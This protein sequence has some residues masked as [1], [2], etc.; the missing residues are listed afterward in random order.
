[1]KLEKQ[2]NQLDQALV[3]ETYKRA[4]RANQLKGLNPRFEAALEKT[5]PPDMQRKNGVHNYFQ[6]RAQFNDVI[7]ISQPGYS[8]DHRQALV[9][10]L[11]DFN[12]EHGPAACSCLLQLEGESWTIQGMS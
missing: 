5:V 7:R 6:W 10:F 11:V 12:G 1:R 9:L 2:M 8:K 3:S 4:R